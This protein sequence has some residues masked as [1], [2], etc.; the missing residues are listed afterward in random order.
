MNPDLTRRYTYLEGLTDKAL[1]E[2]ALYVGKALDPL[3]EASLVV[4]Q[5]DHLPLEGVRE[6]VDLFPPGM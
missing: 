4:E 3:G 5:L 2:L 6:G 1:K